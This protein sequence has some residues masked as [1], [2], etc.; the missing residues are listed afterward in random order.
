LS[1]R[2]NEIQLIISDSGKGFDL[3]TALLGKGLGLT[4]MR[5][6]VRLV[7]GNIA[8]DSRPMGGTTIQISVPLA[9]DQPAE[10]KAI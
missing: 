7:N 10:Q 4:T 5:E 1:E 9:S 6:R 8:I 2:A 3:H